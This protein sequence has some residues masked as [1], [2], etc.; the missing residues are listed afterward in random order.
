MPLFREILGWSYF[1]LRFKN[2][3]ARNMRRE[4]RFQLRVLSYHDMSQADE[5]LFERQLRWI[6]RSWDIVTPE[7]FA[8][9]IDGDI[10]IGR[11]TLILTFDDGTVSNL[12]V[13]ERVLKPLGIQALYF[14][15]T[16]YA[17]LSEEDD[18]QEFA[19][20]RIMLNQEPKAVPEEFRNM[21][22]TD[23]QTLLSE[24]HTIGAHTATHARLSEL[25]GE[26][27]YEEIALGADLL[28]DRLG[29]HIRHFAYPF[30]NFESI[31]A[32]ACDV[33]RQRFDYV[34]TGMRGDNMPDRTSWH[35]RR[36]SN[37]PHDSLWY[38]GAC[39]EGGADFLYSNKHRICGEWVD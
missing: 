2:Q 36:E 9:M 16:Q 26:S 32:K 14:I 30:G 6:M 18:W 1:P 38:T 20:R 31:S 17:L 29:T 12:R 25:E 5:V 27:L 19:S 10:P 24:G 23:L 35:L 21:T 7:E 22:I 28:Q 15:V 33:A 8:A 13:A 11:D 4:P 34:Y 39:L 3:I 37:H